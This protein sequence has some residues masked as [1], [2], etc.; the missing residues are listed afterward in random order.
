MP[1]H[2]A[3]KLKMWAK[4]VN[5]HG[6]AEARLC[7]GYHD[8]PLRGERKGQRSIRLSK[9][10]RAFYI[11]DK[12]VCEEETLK[13]FAKTLDITVSYL[14]DLES[15]RKIVSA[16]TAYEYAEKLRYSTKEFVRLALQ[17]EANKFMTK[18]GFYTSIVLNFEHTSFA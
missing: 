9:A 1:Q 8:E 5:Y 12:N 7:K 3:E 14:S 10:Y 4:T 13:S 11:E 2:I 18:K 15:G 17:D 16:Q 6:I